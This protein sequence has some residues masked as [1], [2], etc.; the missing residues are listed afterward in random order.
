MK[1]TWNVD[2]LVEQWTLLPDELA[3]VN[4]SKTD[5]NRL[6]LAINL[7]YFQVDGKFPRHQHDVPSTVVEHTIPAT[8]C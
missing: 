6:G 5:H 3:F 8:C 2:E 7:K 1:R 4:K